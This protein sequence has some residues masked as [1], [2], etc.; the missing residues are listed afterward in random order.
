[1]DG[2]DTAISIILARKNTLSSDLSILQRTL[3][4][5]EFEVAELKK[6]INKWEGSLAVCKLL[7]EEITAAKAKEIKESTP[8]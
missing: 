7:I 2:I 5:K 3:E 8:K 1:M 4:Q 6:R